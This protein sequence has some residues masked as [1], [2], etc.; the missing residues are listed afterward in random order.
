[1]FNMQIT[2]LFLKGLKAIIN[3]IMYRYPEK[4]E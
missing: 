4:K 3:H 2:K 1:M